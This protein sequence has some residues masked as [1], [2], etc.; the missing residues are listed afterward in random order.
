MM[1]PFLTLDSRTEI[2]H[3]EMRPDGTVKVYMERSDEKD[4]FHHAHCTPNLP[5]FSGK[6]ALIAYCIYLR[7]SRVDAEAEARGEGG[8]TLACHKKALLE[9]A[10]KLRLSVLEVPTKIGGFWVS[11]TYR[12]T[13]LDGQGVILPPLPVQ[14]NWGTWK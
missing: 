5:L 11:T 4:C 1:Y 10:K 7:K 13:Q 14:K 6:R 8:E 2:V 3:S 12:I 9:L